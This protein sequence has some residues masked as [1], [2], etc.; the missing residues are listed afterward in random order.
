MVDKVFPGQPIKA[1]TINGMIDAVT[2]GWVT[3]A[4]Q[5]VYQP[6]EVLVKNWTQTT[7]GAC[8]PFRI[9]GQEFMFEQTESALN[10]FLTF[11]AVLRGHA[12]TSDT[13]SFRIGLTKESIKPGEIGRCSVPGLMGAKVYGGGGNK[14][15]KYDSTAQRLTTTDVEREAQFALI[16]WNNGVTAQDGMYFCFISPLAGVGGS[17]KAYVDA[18]QWNVDVDKIVPGANISFTNSDGEITIKGSYGVSITSGGQSVNITRLIA[19]SNIAFSNNGSALTITGPNSTEFVDS[20]S[21]ATTTSARTLYLGKPFKILNESQ[22]GGTTI[23]RIVLYM[24]NRYY[25]TDVTCSQSGD[26]VV[27]KEMLYSE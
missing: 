6:K 21:P 17:L 23:S 10:K 3:G 20:Y 11:G 8:E 1:S 15:V 16:C 19:G 18:I 5:S 4:P 12:I 13:P 9:S 24:T 22:S 7:W 27:T 26:L 2:N 25:V 14:Y